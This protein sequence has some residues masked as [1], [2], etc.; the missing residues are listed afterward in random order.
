MNWRSFRLRDKFAD[1]MEAKEAVA[2]AIAW[3]N[4]VVGKMPGTRVEEIEIKSQGWD[5]TLSWL[6]RD[7][8]AE[9]GKET[10]SLASRSLNNGLFK[11]RPGIPM[12]RVYKR[13]EIREHEEA[14]KMSVVEWAR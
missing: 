4:T 11:P 1:Q 8:A 5:V 2:K 9:Y 6:E 12:E 14:P 3:Q 7:E 13:F 10:E